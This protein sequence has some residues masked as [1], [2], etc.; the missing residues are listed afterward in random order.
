MD[1]YLNWQEKI[2]SGFR[3]VPLFYVAEYRISPVDKIVKDNEFAVKLCNYTDVYKNT[4][5]T[6]DMEFMEGSASDHEIKRFE[7]R[8]G[9]VLITKDSESWDDIGI[10]AIAKGSFDK[11]ICGYHLALIRPYQN[12]VSPK[13]LYYCFE[14]KQHR[15]QLEIEATGVTRFGIPKNSIG[16]YK[17]PLPNLITQEKIVSHLD[18]EISKIDALI[19][20]KTKLIH[21]LEEKKK[22]IIN[23][24][25][26][27]GLNPNAPMKDS[28]IEWLGEIPEHWE[29]NKV[30]R[31]FNDIGS[32]TTPDTSNLEY[33]E[34]GENNWLIT[35]DLNDK[36]IFETS[37]KITDLAVNHYSTLK[38]FPEN[39]LV[40]AMYGATI[41]K[42]GI[43][44]IPCYTN[45]ACCVLSNSPKVKIE[46]AH[47]YFKA[48]KEWV[49]MFS[50]GGGQPNISQSIIKDLKII[51][52][53]IQEQTQ[54]IDFIQV[55]PQKINNLVEKI[56]YSNNIL[57]EK[58]AA[59]ISAAING[60]LNS[61]LL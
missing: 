49:I 44:R 9:D 29:V 59:I 23:K 20:R 15:T 24:A 51:Y 40:I 35:S 19:E 34:D 22:A 13:F 56:Y 36:E 45:Q 16:K 18:Q 38:L 54:I 12:I 47:L 33:Y 14:S 52:P 27:K 43:I 31:V 11:V 57:K 41:G 10:P 60:K 32:G 50:N 61:Q 58:R 37:K 39:S 7:L 8:D 6:S 2:P 42:T 55:E 46:F 26:T 30:S 4:D 48:I 1:S 5:I 25:V 53:D 17:I 3:V 28:G 21:L